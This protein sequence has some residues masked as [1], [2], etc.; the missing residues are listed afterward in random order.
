MKLESGPKEGPDHEAI[1]VYGRADHWDFARAGGRGFD[2]GGLPQA[3]DQQ[4]HVL[5]LEGEVWRH[6]RFGGQAAEAARGRERQA[7]AAVGRFNARQRRAEGFAVKKILTPA[8]K[9]E[10]VARLVATY[11]MSER[12]ACR[13]IRADRK[14]VRYRSR[15]PPDEDLRG[16]LR[17]LA[18]E[19]R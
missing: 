10:A 4:R 14:T 18:A 15:R 3:R 11:E 2:R 12:R 7:E 6:G 13:L 17:E 9:R 8:A 1:E 19:Q 5:C 16:R